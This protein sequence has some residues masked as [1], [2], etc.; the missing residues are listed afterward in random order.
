[1][2]EW[3]KAGKSVRDMDHAELSEYLSADLHATQQLYNVLRTSYEG[4]STLEPTVKLTN[5]LAV[6]LARIYQR[7]L[8]VDM[9]ALNAVRQ[10]F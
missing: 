5:Q 10:E 7:G 9:T 1:M 2:K 6:H 4:C 3:L 8:K